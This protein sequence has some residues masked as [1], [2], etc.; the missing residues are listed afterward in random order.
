[1]A[2]QQQPQVAQV[3]APNVPLQLFTHHLNQ[4]QMELRASNMCK[5]VRQFTG[6]GNK[7]FLDWVRDMDRCRVAVG[8]DDERMR[9]LALHTLSG[10]AAEYCSRLIQANPAIDWQQLKT[11]LKDRYSDLADALFAKQTMR[12]SRQKKGESVQNFAERLLTLAE[13]AYPAADLMTPVIQSV[14]V[15]IFIDGVADDCMARRLIRTRPATLHDA[16]TQAT[17]D[18]Q[19]SRSFDLRRRGEEPMEV[20]HIATSH[21]VSPK[22]A[23][24]LAELEKAVT[25]LTE[26]VCALATAQSHQSG[27]ARSKYRPPPRQG[28]RPPQPP[29]QQPGGPQLQR[30]SFQN[31]PQYEFASDGQPICF[32][33]KK[34]GHR[35]AQCRSHH[36]GQQQ[37]PLN[38]Q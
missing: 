35:Y 5:N 16:V 11:S 34:V 8:G 30:P 20:D 14:L 32:Y 21:D 1:M 6:E 15:E 38:Y 25:A 22:E 4:V 18:Q 33:C 13:E 23:S 31:S 3:Q 9:M 24:K 12:R 2:N 28:Q 17:E 10:P 29:R 37:G 19:A 7:R 36:A 26:N 27:Q